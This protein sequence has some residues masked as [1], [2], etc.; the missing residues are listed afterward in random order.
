MAPPPPKGVFST[1][2]LVG[3]PCLLG[4]PKSSGFPP[5]DGPEGEKTE[6]FGPLARQ[7]VLS[8]CEVGRI[9]PKMAIF[10]LFDHFWTPF[11]ALC[12]VCLYIC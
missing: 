12:K 9:G 10:G 2:H 3:T 7:G 11:F 4:E 1:S 8:E 5:T 6:L